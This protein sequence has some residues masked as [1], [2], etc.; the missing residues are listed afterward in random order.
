M[1]QPHE[2]P[3]CDDHGP[4]VVSRGFPV[5]LLVVRLELSIVHPSCHGPVMGTVLLVGSR[6]A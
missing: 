3:D 5:F 4:V 2:L 6:G 1:N